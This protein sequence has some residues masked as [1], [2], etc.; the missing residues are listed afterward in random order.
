MYVQN[1]RDMDQKWLSTNYK[2]TER[3]VNKM[4]NELEVEWRTLVIEK[5]QNE[6][7]QP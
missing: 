1:K 6:T 4:I 2:M 3:D 5:M 7:Q